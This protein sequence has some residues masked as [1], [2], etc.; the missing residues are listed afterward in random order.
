[1]DAVRTH[2]FVAYEAAIGNSRDRLLTTDVFRDA[3]IHF[4]AEILVR[5][6]GPFSGPGSPYADLP[7]SHPAI[8][9]AA[10]AAA[11]A[12]RTADERAARG[13]FPPGLHPDSIPSQNMV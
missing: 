10:S 13:G 3:A 12:I 8:L 2:F 1:M 4:G 6:I 9:A 11:R 5:T 7:P